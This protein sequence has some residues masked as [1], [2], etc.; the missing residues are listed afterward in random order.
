MEFTNFIG[1]MCHCPSPRFDSLYHRI[2]ASFCPGHNSMANSLNT[3][4][5]CLTTGD[6]SFANRLS[7]GYYTFP[8]CLASSH[9]ATQNC[10]NGETS[11]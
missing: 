8:D 9:C 3:M 7:T 6:H 2:F 5:H 10:A 4:A 1:P 11:T